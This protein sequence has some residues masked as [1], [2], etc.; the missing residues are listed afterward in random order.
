MELGRA[1]PAL[2]RA[3]HDHRPDRPLRIGSLSAGAGVGADLLDAVDRTVHRRCHGGV[4]GHGLAA[5]HEQRLPAV[6]AQQAGQLVLRDARQQGGIGDLVAVEV[7]HR[8]HGAVAHRIQKLVD[9]PAGGQGPRFRFAVANAGQG[10]QLRVVEHG[11]AG[12]REHVAQF[13]PL[14]DRAGGFRCAVAAD[15]AGEGE[16]LE[17]AAQ[18]GGVLRFVGIDLAVGAIQIG[19]PQHAGCTVA[20]PRQIDHVEVVPADQPVGVGPDEGLAWA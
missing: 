5:L 9:V 7:Q 11:A 14:V 17:E 3:Q 10:D 19:G 4:H 12:V 6:A 20:R 18:A 2:G 16:L 8:Q 13:A 15:V 1:R